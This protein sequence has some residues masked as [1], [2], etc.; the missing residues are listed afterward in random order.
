MQDGPDRETEQLASVQNSGT[1]ATIDPSPTRALPMRPQTAK[2]P[3]IIVPTPRQPPKSLLYKIGIGVL[4]FCI[5]AGGILVLIVQQNQAPQPRA[6]EFNTTELSLKGLTTQSAA[7]TSTIQINGRLYVNDS[8]VLSPTVQPTSPTLGQLYY[9]KTSNQLAYYNGQAFLN[10]ATTDQVA[11]IA[12]NAA[13]TINGTSSTAT[14]QSTATSQQAAS[15]QL[16]DTAPGTQQTGNLNISGTA[17]VGT[18]QTSIIKGETNTPIYIGPT[19]TI[20]PTPIPPGTHATIGLTTIGAI[21]TGPVISGM[22]IATRVTTGTVG[23]TANSITVYLSGG[24]SAK[25]IQVALYDDDGDLPSRPNSLLATSASVT[26]TPN[27]FNTVP[28][29]SVTLSPNTTYWLAFNTDD[30]TVSR[31]YDGGAKTSCFYGLGFGVMPDLFGVGGCFFSNEIYTTYLNYTTTAGPSGSVGQAM[32][33][34]SATGQAIFQNSADS[35]TAFQ[36][37]NATGTTTV[38]NVDTL[39]GRVAIGKATAAYKLDIAAGDINLS[40]NRAIRFGGQQ[41]LTITSAGLS[42]KVTNLASGGNVIMQGDNFVVQDANAMHSSLTVNSSGSATFSNRL[43]TTTAFQIQNATGTTLLRADTTNMGIY[44]GDPAGSASPTLLYLANKNTAADPVGGEGAIYY[45]STLSSFRCYF[46]GTWHN[47][48]DLEPQHNFS[49]YDEFA[50]G[51]TS[52]TGAIGSLGWNAVA[53]GANG[54]LSLNPATPAPSADRPGVLMLRTPATINQGST[55]LLG[56]SG[57]GSML[58]SAGTDLKTA[59]AVGNAANQVL[60]V[61]IHNETSATTQPLS[62]IWWEANPAANANWRYCYGNGTSAS[63][64]ASTVPIAANAWAS[65]E[66]RIAATGTGTSS[67][68]FVINGNSY[69]ISNATVDSTNQ[70]S[71]ALSSYNTDGSARDC[72]W[73]YF[74][75]TG[76]TSATR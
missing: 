60:R 39:N 7:N 46:S 15:V 34:L 24:S 71:P 62:G 30:T 65:L 28:I 54:S 17:Q 41:A 49:L 21:S 44:I 48:A 6:A 20:T 68:Y 4:L 35:A 10:V 43:N 23:G 42:T 75:L 27:A 1:Q 3:S 8:I 64:A 72:F 14:V 45:N 69:Q 29:P 40:V 66:I 50:G 51:Q 26:L 5:V 67:V 38:F 59:V 13:A 58:L 11:T 36:I 47:C 9:D 76:I 19:S 53:I 56:D 37:Q 22:I 18:L 55:L 57:G 73:D 63:C 74:H 33:T 2:P 32:L 61:G 12:T 52:F 25:H 31:M 16:Q 70:L